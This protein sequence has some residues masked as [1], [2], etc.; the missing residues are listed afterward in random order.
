MAIPPFN[1]QPMRIML[2]LSFWPKLNPLNS[3]LK[4]SI[5][6]WR[7]LGFKRRLWRVGSSCLRL[8][9]LSNLGIYL[10]KDYLNQGLN[11]SKRNWWDGNSLL[12]SCLRESVDGHFWSN[13]FC[14]N[15]HEK[16]KYEESSIQPRLEWSWGCLYASRIVPDVKRAFQDRSTSFLYVTT[17]IPTCDIP[18]FVLKF[19][20][21]RS[22]RFDWRS[23]THTSCS[24]IYFWFPF[25]H[26]T[27][28][29]AIHFSG[30][31]NSSYNLKLCLHH[32]YFIILLLC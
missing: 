31:Q 1:F 32:I 4:A 26:F 14:L 17:S 18:G 13:L 5:I 21:W 19:K 12:H 8:L 28:E 3:P 16:G 7:L 2:E 9:P 23:W 25:P 27:R 29:N 24:L 10:P 20:F 22:K 30:S 11:I 15:L 6:I